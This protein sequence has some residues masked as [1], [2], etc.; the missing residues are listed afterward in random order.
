MSEGSKLLEA[1]GTHS[2]EDSAAAMR[3]LA[4]LLETADETVTVASDGSPTTVSAPEGDVEFEPDVERETE[5]DETEVEIEVE[6][7]WGVPVGPKER[8]EKKAAEKDEGEVQQG[9]EEQGE[10]QEGEQTQA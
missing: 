9:E 3:A 5:D 4:G 8:D 10:L 1:E 2:P 6:L 7:S